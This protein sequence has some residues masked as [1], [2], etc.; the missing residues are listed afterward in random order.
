MTESTTS[1]GRS[2]LCPAKWGNCAKTGAKTT[3]RLFC[4]WTIAGTTSGLLG[5]SS[6]GGRS[7][8]ATSMGGAEDGR[9]EVGAEGRQRR[10]L[11]SA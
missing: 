9:R 3:R 2:G 1:W 11:L 10:G 8:V 5:S 7:T 6:W 4:L